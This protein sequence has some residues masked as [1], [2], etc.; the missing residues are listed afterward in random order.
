MAQLL[1]RNLEDGV[2]ARLRVLAAE[3]GRS[4]EEEVRA[5]LRDAVARPAEPIGGLG[6]ELAALFKGGGLQANEELPEMPGQ[7]LQPWNFGD[8]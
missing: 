4:M 7:I 5:I 3:H 8:C 6:T 2:K 1:V